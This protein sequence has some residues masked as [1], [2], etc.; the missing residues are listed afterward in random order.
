MKIE[1]ISL[2]KNKLAGT[3]KLVEATLKRVPHLRIIYN[4]NLPASESEKL[5]AKF[6]ER[7]L[8]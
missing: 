6:G 3:Y 5:T 8:V 2:S 4:S 7:Y 1:L